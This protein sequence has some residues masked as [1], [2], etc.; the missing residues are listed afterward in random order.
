[1]RIL[2]TGPIWLAALAVGA[3]LVV[4]AQAQ[5]EKMITTTKTAALG[6]V[7]AILAP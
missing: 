3:L 4:P 1:M 5:L 2:K 6:Q 7:R